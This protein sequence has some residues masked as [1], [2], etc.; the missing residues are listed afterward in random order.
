MVTVILAKLADIKLN[1]QK[2][3]INTDRRMLTAS[4]KFLFLLRGLFLPASIRQFCA[5][6][7]RR[8]LKLKFYQAAF[9]GVVNVAS[10]ARERTRRVCN[11]NY[12]VLYSC[13]Y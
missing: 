8:R 2:V 1:E 6:L 4:F 7:Q 3:L 9:T 11:R 10:N 5:K 13:T 12:G